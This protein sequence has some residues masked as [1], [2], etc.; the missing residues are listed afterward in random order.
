MADDPNIRDLDT[1]EEVNK[2]LEQRTQILNDLSAAYAEE[3]KAAKQAVAAEIAYIDAKERGS[4]QLE[5]YEKRMNEAND[6]LAEHEKEIQKALLAE[7]LFV[8]ALR[9][10]QKAVQAAEAEM[11]QYTKGIVET[12]KSLEKLA[13]IDMSKFLKFGKSLKDTR[14]NLSQLASSAIGA[15]TSTIDLGVQMGRSRGFFVGFNKEIHDLAENNKALSLTNEK[16]YASYGSLAGGLTNFLSLSRK[17][18]DSV[19]LLTVDFDKFGVSTD[20]TA[21]LLDSMTYA[22]GLSTASSLEAAEGLKGF[23]KDTGRPLQGVVQDL[24]GMSSQLARFGKRGPEVFKKLGMQ[25]RRLGLTI[26]DAF[27]LTEQFDTFESAANV[28]GRLNAQLGMQLNS[29]EIMSASSEDRLEILREEFKL[30]GL[31]FQ[32]MGRRQK[33]MVAEIVAGGDVE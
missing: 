22:F 9:D 5:F 7:E 4:S 29:V 23:A 17:Q 12:G 18:R 21:K 24:S 16:L 1:E 32:S 31:N 27:D 14:V 30:Q 26:K 19:A 11:E 8:R 20:E 25:A 6:S 33:Q 10:Q 2:I 28:A 13:G 3:G 15:M